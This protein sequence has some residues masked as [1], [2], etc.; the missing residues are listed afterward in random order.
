MDSDA[1]ITVLI[2]DDDAF[3][4][5]GMA[6]IFS[7]T[8]DIVVVGSVSDGDEVPAAVSSTRPH[9]VLMDL[10]MS[11]VGGLEATRALMASLNPPKV[12][13][14]TSM[15]VDDLVVHAIEAGAHSFLSKSEPPE[16]YHQSIRAV[17]AGNTLFSEDS[18]RRIVASTRAPRPTTTL[19]ALT[20]REREVLS[21]M[22]SGASNPDIARRLFMSETTVKSHLSAVNH[23]LQV[24][25]RVEA[26]L[27][28]FR[29]GLIE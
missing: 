10:K 24:S 4:R 23:K 28:A 6:D 18:L 27:A 7:A 29:A 14:M 5:R 17:A 16:T 11:R 25:N 13:A 20:E 12:V 1:V 8:E 19:D 26:A 21:V 22:A 2:V 3:V 15:D 9:V